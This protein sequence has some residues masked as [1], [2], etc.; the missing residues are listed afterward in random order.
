MNRLQWLW[1]TPVACADIL[2]PHQVIAPMRA[3]NGRRDVPARVAPNAGET[4]SRTFFYTED[5]DGQK[6]AA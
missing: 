6:V 1:L 5:T 3:Q 2:T 4:Q